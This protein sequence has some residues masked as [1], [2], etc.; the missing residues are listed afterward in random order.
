MLRFDENLGRL[1]LKRT[2]LMSRKATQQESRKSVGFIN[3][4]NRSQRIVRLV[5]SSGCRV[6]RP[7]VAKHRIN[8]ESAKPQRSGKGAHRPWLL[9]FGYPV[10][11][12][13]RRQ[14][15]GSG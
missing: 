6:A 11:V 8:P 10:R 3:H 5:R 14:S 4:R 7:A 2:S 15:W 9:E 13:P 1:Q 12:Q